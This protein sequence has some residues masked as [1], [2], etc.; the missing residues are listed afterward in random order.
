MK[1]IV[2]VGLVHDSN[3]GDR[4][5]YEA[6]RGFLDRC[7]AEIGM[8]EVE[9]RCMDISG[10]SISPQSSDNNNIGTRLLSKAAA[11]A[12]R[13]LSRTKAGRN[14]ILIPNLR[15]KTLGKCKEL[16]DQNTKAIIFTGGGLIKFKQQYCHHYIDVITEFADLRGIPVML[17]GVGVEGYDEQ[18]KDCILLKKA[19]NRKCVKM[20][21]TRDDIDLLNRSYIT[22]RSIIT[23]RVADPACSVSDFYRP[24][25]TEKR[26]IGLGLVREGLFKNYG[27]S[28][29]KQ[30]MLDL[31]KGICRELDARG[32][33]YKIFTNGLHSDYKFAEEFVQDM[34]MDR[35]RDILIPRP[36]ETKALEDTIAG[37]KAVIACRLHA[38][39]IAYSY[40]VPG[41][42]L[43]WNR[44]QIMFG[45]SIGHRER[46][47]TSDKFD[48]KLIV[49][50]MEKALAEG[51][52]EKHRTEY[53][54]TTKKYIDIFL[55]GI[56]DKK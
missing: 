44:K 30:Q 56:A 51:Y 5:I 50:A 49:D 40:A 18:N 13:H 16:I 28:F 20:I 15:R 12:R 43:V 35:K 2:L 11:S 52:D 38:A 36:V 39:I 17:S 26:Y 6:M 9:L 45:E 42:E 19:L 34:G 33:E 10:R 25:N 46:F 29:G 14:K 24:Q 32:Y 37:F 22:D 4:V 48:P 55:R 3:L 23:A 41:V 8:G 31:W 54:K 27:V 21:T 47:I 7:L 1:N 53:C